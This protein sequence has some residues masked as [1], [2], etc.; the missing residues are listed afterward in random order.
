MEVQTS[1]HGDGFDTMLVRL[2][3][4]RGEVRDELIDTLRE[5][6]NTAEAVL[7]AEV[8][9]E[10]GALANSIRVGGIVYSPGA[11]GG[12]G[13]WEVE[14]SVGEGIPYLQQVIEGSGI[15]GPAAHPIYPAKGNVMVIQK[16]GE[17]PRYVKWSRGQEPDD[18]WLI[19]AQMAVNEVIERAMRRIDSAGI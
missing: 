5:A 11:A 16:Q 6:A 18:L 8:P 10:S 9:R 4:T 7:V 12:G 14:I 17:E 13:Y 19:K 2:R 3:A 15:Y 1:I